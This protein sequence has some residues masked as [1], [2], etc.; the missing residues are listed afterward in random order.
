MPIAF[1]VALLPASLVASIVATA[2]LVPASVASAQFASTAASPLA[3]WATASDDVQPKLAA[4]GAGGSYI[5]FLSGSGYDVRLAR[6]DAAGESMWNGGSILVEDRTLSSTTDYGLAADDAGNAY[7]AY[8]QGGAIILSSFD[9]TGALRWRKTVG[10]GMVG[11]VSVDSLG[12]PWVA[13]LEGSNTRVQRFD[14]SGNPLLG[15]GVLLAE[16][17]ATQ[18]ASD[19]QPSLDGAMIVACVRYTTFTGAK[20]LRAHR[21]E[22]DGSRPWAANGVSVFTT[23]SLQF[24]NFPTFLPDGAGGAY[25]TWYATS[26]LQ[27]FVQRVDASGAVQYGTSGIA[28]TTTTT[29]AERVSPSITVGDDGRLY[30]FWSQHTPN[31]SIYGVYGQCFAKGV[32]QWGASGMAVEPLATTYSRSWATAATADGGVLCFYDDSTSAVQDT[33]ECARMNADGSVAW[34]APVATNSGV[35]YRLVAQPSLAD[36]SVLAW[37][38]GASTGASDVFAARIDGAGVLGPGASAPSPDL[39]GNGIVNAADLAVLLSQ[40]GSAGSADL[41]EDGNVGAPDLAILLGAWT[42]K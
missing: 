38:G 36:G 33:I 10:S 22:A 11:R 19:I 4:D 15:A 17:G 14:A 2:A 6:L 37:Q 18:F 7:L 25:F 20:I 24:G 39:D 3:V 12:N 27:C 5:S 34:R 28:V 31:S 26:P 29:N 41:D 35:K 21:I 8:D 23:G 1:R 42:G 13:F 9:P 40:W 32:R 16:T 30:A